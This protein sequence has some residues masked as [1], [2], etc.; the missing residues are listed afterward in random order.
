MRVNVEAQPFDLVLETLLAHVGVLLRQL[1][2]GLLRVGGYGVKGVV[3]LLSQD[4]HISDQDGATQ[5]FEGSLLY[6]WMRL[7]SVEGRLV[8][9]VGFEPTTS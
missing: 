3:S 2:D 9:A 8:G 6:H 7:R 4:P 1:Q 5:P